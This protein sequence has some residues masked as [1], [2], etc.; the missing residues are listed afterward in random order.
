MTKIVIIAKSLLTR[1]LGRFF[2]VQFVLLYFVKE[3]IFELVPVVIQSFL[4]QLVIRPCWIPISFVAP[5][6]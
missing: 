5:N 6:V 2:Y 4:F 1:S 3:K